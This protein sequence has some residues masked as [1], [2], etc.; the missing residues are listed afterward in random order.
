[1]LL[2]F[3]EQELYWGSIPPDDLLDVVV[4]VYQAGTKREQYPR[5]N[6]FSRNTRN[7]N[8]INFLFIDV[9]CRAGARG[10]YHPGGHGQLH[11]RLGRPRQCK[12]IFR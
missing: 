11:R 5:S 10:D 1:M 3:V 4:V 8:T 12:A 2:L 9:V 7:A 6:R